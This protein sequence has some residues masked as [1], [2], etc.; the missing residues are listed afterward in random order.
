MHHHSLPSMMGASCSPPPSLPPFFV[1]VVIP[2]CC[3]H[4]SHGHCHG[5]S[6]V[7]IYN[8]P[9]RLPP[10]HPHHCKLLCLPHVSSYFG[11]QHYFLTLSLPFVWLQ[12]YWFLLF[13]MLSSYCMWGDM[14]QSQIFRLVRHQNIISTCEAQGYN[15]SYLVMYKKH[16]YTNWW[17][18]EIY[19]FLLGDVKKHS[20]HSLGRHQNLKSQLV[21]HSDGIFRI[22]GLAKNINIV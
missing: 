3:R 1:F 12:C 6:L 5:H 9:R 19:F 18:T 7:S 15:F 2:R 10:H 17:G 8:V 14:K 4:H 13:D 21:R 16:Q 22:W 20:I 11:L